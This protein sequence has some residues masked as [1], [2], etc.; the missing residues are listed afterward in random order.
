[1]RTVPFPAL[2]HIAERSKYEFIFISW[3]FSEWHMQNHNKE[4]EIKQNP[5]SYKQLGNGNSC[6]V[7]AQ[8]LMVTMPT[9]SPR[10]SRL[11]S[12]PHRVTGSRC[13]HPSYLSWV[14]QWSSRCCS[15]VRRTGGRPP[16]ARPRS[17]L[18]TR[19]PS[20]RTPWLLPNGRAWGEEKL[21]PTGW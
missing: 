11:Q 14:I 17:H 1:M 20:R 2:A 4:R 10:T 19:K 6:S 8:K 13:R 18:R 21:S 16:S 3:T 12:E 7:R 5:A 9:S 15:A